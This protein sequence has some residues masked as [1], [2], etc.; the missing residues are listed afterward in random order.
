MKSKQFVFN[1]L[2][3]HEVENVILNYGCIAGQLIPEL[4][5]EKHGNCANCPFAQ[6]AMGKLNDCTTQLQKEFDHHIKQLKIKEIL[7]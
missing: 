3:K 7:K 6:Y 2:L 4:K 5:D 1:R